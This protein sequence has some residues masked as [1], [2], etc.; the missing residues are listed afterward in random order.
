MPSLAPDDSQENISITKDEFQGLLVISVW[1]FLTT[2]AIIV[3]LQHLHS[4]LNRLSEFIER[5][6]A[7]F[8]SMSDLRI[9]LASTNERLRN[10]EGAEAVAEAKYVK[11]NE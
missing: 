11:V 6:I 3:Y 7:L 10:L 2:I 1:I 4:K 9:T 8:R 5:E